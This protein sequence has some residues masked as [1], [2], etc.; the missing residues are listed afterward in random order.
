MP[1]LAVKQADHIGLNV[2]DLESSLTFYQDLFGFTL[3][4]R[5]DE[6]KQ[7]FIGIEGLVLGLMENPS[8]DFKTYTLAHLAVACSEAE[9]PEVVAYLQQ[10]RIEIVSGPKPQRGGEMILFRDPSGNLLEICYPSLTQWQMS[11][12]P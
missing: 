5:W 2:V 6:P 8:Y 12:S 11:L 7:A 4:A 9:F 10:H 1:L 3:I